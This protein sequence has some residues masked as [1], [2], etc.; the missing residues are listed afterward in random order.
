MKMVTLTSFADHYY[1]PPPF[2]GLEELVRFPDGEF[3]LNSIP[4]S[5]VWV[6]SDRNHRFRPEIHQAD[7]GCGMTALIISPVEHREAADAIYAHLRKKNILGRGNHFID[8]CSPLDILY[9]EKREPHQVLL[10]HTHGAR[11]DVPRTLTQACQYQDQASWYRKEL[12]ETLARVLGVSST[13]LGDWNHNSVQ[14]ENGKIIYRR[15]VVKVQPGK[16]Y[17]LPAHLGEQILIY[18]IN[19][20]SLP[21]YSSMP[22]AT[23][24]SGPRGETKVTP[25]EAATLRQ[26]VY[27]PAGISDRSLRTE[28]PSCYNDFDKIFDKLRAFFV[29]MGETQILSYVGKI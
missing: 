25:E 4:N 19:E 29:P 26:Q 1:S 18:T 8:I 12:G 27:I 17:F 6:F 9:E 13:L 28:H 5:T 16:V 11:N 15:G 24:R 3:K 23:G 21:P 22:H 20:K 2:T 7:I 10:I 14:Q